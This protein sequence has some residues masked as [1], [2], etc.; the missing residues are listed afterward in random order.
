MVQLL[1]NIII[2]IIGI[3]TLYNFKVGYLCIFIS[4]I[5]IPHMVRFG[6][7]AWSLSIADTYSL[8]L[9]MSFIIHRNQLT[10]KIRYPLILKKYFIIEITTTILLIFLSSGYIPYSYQIT[11]FTKTI[12]QDFIFMWMGYWAFTNI[13]NKRTINL[14]LII[15]NT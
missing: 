15:F 14:L 5:L 9:I 6:I 7:G 1:F 13:D 8:I 11:S 3:L 10:R 4:R 2:L 12:I